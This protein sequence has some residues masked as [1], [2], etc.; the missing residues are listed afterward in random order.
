MDIDFQM[1]REDEFNKDELALLP[2]FVKQQLIVQSLGENCHD[3]TCCLHTKPLDVCCWFKTG[4][5][6]DLWYQMKI[7]DIAKP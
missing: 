1:F 7:Q 6:V 2:S 5:H 4:D 3:C